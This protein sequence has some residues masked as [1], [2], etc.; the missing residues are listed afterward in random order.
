MLT[1]GGERKWL[2]NN[3]LADREAIQARVAEMVTNRKVVAVEPTPHAFPRLYDAAEVVSL[4]EPV[5][6]VDG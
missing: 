3:V 6:A 4:L 2:T 5:A 1:P